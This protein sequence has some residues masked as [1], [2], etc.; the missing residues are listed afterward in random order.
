MTTF[1]I[2]AETKD[3]CQALAAVS[4]FAEEKVPSFATVRLFADENNTWVTATNGNALGLALAS[5]LVLT[6][7][8]E[9]GVALDSPVVEVDLLPVQCRA[10]VSL[11][12]GGVTNGD[13]DDEPGAEL[14]IEV[15][16]DDVIVTD[17]SGLLEGQ[18]LTLPRPPTVEHAAAAIISVDKLHTRGHAP[19]KGLPPRYSANSLQ[20]MVK[21]AKTYGHPLTLEHHAPAEETRAGSTLVRVGDSFLGVLVD[22]WTDEG[23]ARTRATWAEDWTRRL[24]AFRPAALAATEQEPA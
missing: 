2:H 7:A 12:K 24:T 9:D 21:A 11:F 13:S 14:A 6:A 4:P 20:L 17:V 23:D 22:A 8:D 19:M 15:T 1:T 18:S 5:T 10:I 16:T 3:L